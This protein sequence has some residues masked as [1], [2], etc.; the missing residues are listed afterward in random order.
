MVLNNTGND[1][2]Y[3]PIHLV[4]SELGLP[5]CCLLP[6]FYLILFYENLFFADVFVALQHQIAISY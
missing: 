5:I 2:R 4:A 3:D 6:A 1:Q